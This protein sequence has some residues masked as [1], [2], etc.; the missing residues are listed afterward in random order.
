MRRGSQLTDKY[1]AARQPSSSNQNLPL[2]AIWNSRVF[3]ASGISFLQLALSL[4]PCWA[5]S[6]D[7]SS[8]ER[9]VTAQTSGQISVGGSTQTVAPGDMLTAA[10]HLALQQA[11]AGGQTLLI[12]EHGAAVGGSL[13]IGANLSSISSLNIP[14]GVTAVQTSSSLN[15]TGN[16]TNSG[17]LYT[18]PNANS[19]VIS[20]LNIYNNPGALISSIAGATSG[21]SSSAPPVNLSLIAVS[22][23]INAGQIL[24]SA[25]LTLSAGGNIVNALPTGIAGASPLMQAAN[26]LNLINGS[27]QLV[28]S[29][30]M[31]AITGN[32]NISTLNPA[33]LLLNNVNGQILA[34]L[35]SINF[36][37]ENFIGKFDTLVDGGSLFSKTLNIWSGTG[38]S[39][40]ELD[41]LTGKVNISAGT[42]HI[43]SNTENLHLGSMNILGDPT[44]FNSGNILIDS[45]ISTNGN[46]LAIVAG[47]AIT[48]QSGA[49]ISS[50]NPAAAGG[51]VLI[52]AGVQFTTAGP[53]TGGTDTSSQ[54][55]GDIA[56]TLTLT[57]AS[58]QAGNINL[59]NL[60]MFTAA[61]AAPA[62]GGDVTI[63]AFNGSINAG[64]ISFSQTATGVAGSVISV[65]STTGFQAGQKVVL[66]QGGSSA[67]QTITAV[68]AGASITVDSV[69]AFFTTGT[70]TAS[71]IQTSGDNA[72]SGNVVMI[73]GATS[74]TGIIS[75]D[76]FTAGSQAANGGEVVLLTATPSIST[77]ITILNGIVTAGNT[78]SA[79]GSS[80]TNASSITT[81]NIST[82]GA[83][84]TIASGTNVSIGGLIKTGGSPT[85]GN[86]GPGGQLAIFAPGNITTSA[87]GSGID[88]SG[89]VLNIS[90]G[91]VLLLA[92]SALT[93]AYSH[94]FNTTDVL[95]LTVT[96][97]TSTGAG[98]IDLTGGGSFNA[99]T[100]TTM[101]N[102]TPSG[103][104]AGGNV[105]LV[106]LAGS[107]SLPSTLTVTT[108]GLSNGN[109]IGAAAN[110][111]GNVN[112]LAGAAS[113]NSIS[114]GNVNTSGSNAGAGNINVLT[115]QASLNQGAQ[116][117]YQVISNQ[118]AI[119][120]TG[121]ITIPTNA[122]NQVIL[123]PASA[124]VGNLTAAGGS[125][126]LPP[127]GNTQS[128][129]TTT[130]NLQ[131]GQNLSVGNVTN[132]NNALPAGIYPGGSGC[133]GCSGQPASFININSGA[134]LTFSG[135]PTIS[136]KA[137]A[138][139]PTFNLG[140]DGGSITISAQ[141]I[142][143][144]ATINA[145]GTSGYIAGE[146]TGGNGGTISV[147]STSASS[148]ITIAATALSISA[149]G[150]TAGGNGG[151]VTLSSG[152][153]ISIAPAS[154][155]VNPQPGSNVQFSPPNFLNTF[156]SS[157]FGAII[158][159]NAGR[160]LF[161]SGN[162]GADGAESTFNA[163]AG[164]PGGDGGTINI[165][166][167]SSAP[168]QIGA[169]AAV[170]NGVQGNLTANG[171]LFQAGAAAA[172]GNGGSI[173][174]TNLG[175]GGI[176]VAGNASPPPA[177][178]VQ[179]SGADASTNFRAGSAGS[180]SFTGTTVLVSS[181]LNADGGASSASFGSGNGGTINF[182][183]SSPVAFI[184]GTPTTNGVAGSIS[185]SGA[186]VGAAP[187]A[188][189]AAVPVPPFGNGG[190]VNITNKSGG[191]TIDSI[192]GI[193]V[194]AAAAT[195]QSAGGTG[196]TIILNAPE[197]P[198]IS[199][200]ALSA[201]GGAASSATA[202]D[203]G[204]GGIITITSKDL[205]ANPFII[206]AAPVTSGVT[207]SIQA[208]G[209]S[210][211]T[212]TIN[213]LSTGGIQIDSGALT[214]TATANLS[215]LF[216]GG[217]GGTLILNAQGGPLQVTGDLNVSGS[218]G[219]TAGT[220]FNFGGNGGRIEI[221]VNS[222][223]NPFTLGS[224]PGSSNNYVS[225]NLIANGGFGIAGNGFGGQV[226]ITNLASDIDIGANAI[227]VIGPAATQSGFA[228]DGGRITLNASKGTVTSAAL[229]ADGGA[230]YLP[231][232]GTIHYAKGFAGA[233]FITVNS[234]SAF[235]IGGTG[236]GSVSSLSASGWNG[237][238][239]SVTNS[240]AGGITVADG[241]IN[242]KAQAADPAVSPTDVLQFGQRNLGGP[243][244]TITLNASGGP[245][246]ING[247]L[248]AS[249]GPIFEQLATNALP[250]ASGTTNITV[251]SVAGFAI[252]QEVL[253]SD[254]TSS[255]RQTITAVG[256]GSITVGMLQNTYS[257][258]PTVSAYFLE[259]VSTSPI[260]SFTDVTD[261][262]PAIAAGS[263]SINVA[264]GNGFQNGQQVLL[265]NPS[266]M[267]DVTNSLPV[268]AGTTVLTVND[269]SG[270]AATQTVLIQ[271][272]GGPPAGETATIASVSPGV[273][274]T[275]S[276]G[277]SNTYTGI[278]TVT[279]NSVQQ[280]M[281]VSSTTAS[282][283]TFTGAVTDVYQQAVTAVAGDTIIAL[284]Q[285][286]GFMVNQAVSISGGGLVE[287]Q[288]ITAVNTPNAN[289]ITTGA[290]YN[291][292]ATP[293]TVRAGSPGGSINLS[294]GTSITQ[295]AGVVRANSISAAAP[296]GIGSSAQ[297]LNVDVITNLAPGTLAVNTS[298]PAFINNASSSVSL[299]SVQAAS[300]TFNSN[301][302]ISVDGPI[303]TSQGGASLVN[304]NTTLGSININNQ[305]INM[306]NTL[307]IAGPL[308]IQNNNLAGLIN[309]ADMVTVNANGMT[310]TS[311]P[312]PTTP[313]QGSLPANVT[314]T[315]A[316]SPNVYFGAQG[317]TAAAPMT[318]N[319]AQ[320]AGNIIFNGNA[321]GTINF[322]GG[323]VLN[324]VP[325]P[326]L[327]PAAPPPT[328]PLTSP[329]PPFI[330]GPGILGLGATRPFG[331]IVSS[332]QTP[333]SNPE[334]QIENEG[335]GS[336]QSLLGSATNLLRAHLVYNDRSISTITS[337]DEIVNLPHQNGL[338]FASKDLK[339]QTGMAQISVKQG[340]AVLILQ[341][342]TD[343]A[344][345]NLHDERRSAVLATVDG[346]TFD[347]PVGRQV[348]VTKQLDTHFDK[349]NPS[350]I[351]YRA[352][353]SA[354]HGDK[355]IY[356][357]EFSPLSALTSVSKL[358]RPQDKLHQLIAKRMLKTA[359]AIY[360]MG[361]QDGKEAYKASK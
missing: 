233:I 21:L 247:T 288:F 360:V 119:I 326:T 103:G 198:V 215:N 155:T 281:T 267:Q 184:V 211:G 352:L 125:V 75:G 46:A 358:L 24:S 361:R 223:A 92:G 331:T 9:N 200:L 227:Q 93:S 226:S 118:T 308:L 346:K 60:S 262:N 126:P 209:Y 182:V 95:N 89:A 165:T 268:N 108:G 342:G 234:S 251:G 320:G 122:A 235:N 86:T 128:T 91:N 292:F 14:S 278:P 79:A 296:S 230:G 72:A 8:Q 10:E 5:Q 228:G 252:G 138:S 271:G 175:I 334:Q 149:M 323:L 253:I 61:A 111:N 7:L 37:D 238:E 43:L 237:G 232:P 22:D 166:V 178:S 218:T 71:G 185:A 3:F 355:H 353:N 345:F 282:S 327:P 284:P 143:G 31:S 51:D 68:T 240:G 73:A 348:T 135:N 264:D 140:V 350:S 188:G 245:L 290:L 356:F 224:A 161:V 69:P 221:T 56:T 58:G 49:T 295:T 169:S 109:A 94:E 97:G 341:T 157:G 137:T 231:P 25:S 176:T 311:G 16:L 35:G 193:D 142:T 303:T 151:R 275:L 41:E 45:N 117:S 124:S 70:V 357:A 347:V 187:P 244:G 309:F 216:A 15:I 64:G 81:G 287:Q 241:S 163:G 183:T 13:N 297:P 20:A 285:S 83:P 204:V 77:A 317:L 328:P 274:I 2:D 174:V 47:G 197:G 325:G 66:S 286:Q 212:V 359:A 279:S 78:Y 127:A 339:I 179:V 54:G 85:V 351:G 33:N 32:V 277:T 192:G 42:A 319:V 324:S 191:I 210:G 156:V 36:R 153:D 23:I 87:A 202:N 242:I 52:I 222:S 257:T 74:G 167:N 208:N 121:S 171:N 50:T 196:G 304:T 310:I 260:T 164:N 322:A 107:I 100:F 88:S 172:L 131:A 337:S 57:G 312:A 229:S 250:I 315:P 136:S 177:A 354:R 248:D 330:L 40:L 300:F 159:I 205:T 120:T 344:I 84:V 134:T 349:L 299:S 301:G 298:G 104:T 11:L 194:S 236:T 199:Q 294:S 1:I 76:I 96:T 201:N 291:N 302:N 65:G 82:N 261:S 270:F 283:I 195:S 307:N 280:V 293:P 203:A 147:T 158:N 19:A 336:I 272:A 316:G 12:S 55:A 190:T 162:F 332:D 63:I 99:T 313:V 276:A 62:A 145:D 150:D 207:G 114:I 306:A 102:Q 168:F 170:T 305:P 98:N 265:F 132:T 289:T 148:D 338:I 269:T 173:S 27:S 220:G 333:E 4:S 6:L 318:I 29:G 206:G 112:I 30:I 321:P 34:Q 123:Q 225:G 160:N 39:S 106:S 141:S 243:G 26:N 259:Q 101:G 335:M 28:N 329:S 53:G 133:S 263:T 105:E 48:S 266:F 115:T 255:E 130:I 254:G 17:T 219:A 80:A 90:G 340:S 38:N 146:G 314:V 249:G 44:Y 139:N 217:N 246:T 256:A 214:V 239:I 144:Q 154:F 273:S 213:S 343:L 189:P 18:L 67:T 186:I 113:G 180:I 116:Y 258:Q 129:L 181:N 110:Q 152:R 59:S